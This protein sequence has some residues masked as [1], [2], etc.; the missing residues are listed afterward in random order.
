M[1]TTKLALY[2]GVAAIV[3]AAGA[4]TLAIQTGEPPASSADLAATAAPETAITIYKSPSCGC[5]QSWVEHLEANGFRTN[6]IDTNNIN[7]VKQ[8]HGVPRE[9]ASC[10]TALVGDL[11]VEGHVPAGDIRAFLENP[12]FNT[13]GLSVPGMVQGSPGMETGQKDNYQVIAFRANGQHSVFREHR[14]Y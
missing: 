6:T 3:L 9:M 5:C 14:D 2:T 10:H 13:V 1:K 12:R 7:E 11:V 8:A 4:T